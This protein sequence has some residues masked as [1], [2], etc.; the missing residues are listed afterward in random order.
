MVKAPLPP[1]F[2]PPVWATKNFRMLVIFATMGLAVGAVFVFDIGPKLTQVRTAK[3]LAKQADPN[4]FVPPPAESGGDVK[5]EGMLNKVKD[6]TSIDDQ[7]EAYQYMIRVLARAEAG[8]V[9][10]DAKYVEYPTYGKMPAELRGYTTKVTALLLRSNPIRVDAAPGGVTFI[11]RTYLS[12]FAGKEGYVV[13]LLEPPGELEPKKTA[14]TVDAIFLKLGTYE[15]VKGPVQ[16]PF[17]LG[18]G[19]RV[20][21]ERMADSPIAGLSGGVMAGI[22]VGTMVLILALTS[23]MFRKSKPPAPKGPEARM[24]VLKA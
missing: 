12:D 7:D 18:K 23:L 13:D 24:E 1:N 19:L 3:S 20:V 11:H 15:G 6:G 9:G 17:F 16:A 5:Y 21:K 14:V 2:E 10:R 22:A 8:T 4:A